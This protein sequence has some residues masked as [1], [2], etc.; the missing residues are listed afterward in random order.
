MEYSQVLGHAIIF[1]I[2]LNDRALS[3]GIVIE[4]I[5]D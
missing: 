1:S 5:F 3:L 2:H 4:N